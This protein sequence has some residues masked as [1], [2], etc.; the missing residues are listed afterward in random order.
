MILQWKEILIQ[1][2]LLVFLISVC[3]AN[4]SF[5]NNTVYAGLIPAFNNTT[6]P[7]PNALKCIACR[8]SEN[9]A[10][11]MVALDAFCPMG[12]K[13]CYTEHSFNTTNGRSLDVFKRCAR[14]YDC[15][16]DTVGCFT[17]EHNDVRKCISCCEWGI[18]NRDV[19]INASTAT[20][21]TVVPPLQ[22][23]NPSS[24]NS[25]F[26]STQLLLSMLCTVFLLIRR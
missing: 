23:D 10:C 4:I 18:C 25:L 7:F 13:F 8:K 14:E 22:I 2:I 12:T 11:N 16:Q 6:T 20:F 1:T 21:A 17:T 15:S 3:S 9:E 24:T 19:P 5:E 26:S